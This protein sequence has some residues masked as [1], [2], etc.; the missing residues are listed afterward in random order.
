VTQLT[1][2]K[3]L[4][5]LDLLH[6]TLLIPVALIVAFGGLVIY[7]RSRKKVAAMAA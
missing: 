1:D 4:A 7:M 2:A 3:N 5:G 6:V